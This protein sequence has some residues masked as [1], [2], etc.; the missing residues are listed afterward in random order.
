MLIRRTAG[1]KFR[2]FCRQTACPFYF[3]VEFDHETCT[4]SLHFTQYNHSHDDEP[5][6]EDLMMVD[7]MFYMYYRKAGKKYTLTFN[8]E[9]NKSIVTIVQ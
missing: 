6:P 8:N 5:Y 2:Y 7:A 9:K 1:E 3:Q 4:Q